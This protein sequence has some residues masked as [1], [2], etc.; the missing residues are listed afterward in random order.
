MK[1]DDRRWTLPQALAVI[2]D[3][4][5]EA[6]SDVE[7]R[8]GPWARGLELFD[9]VNETVR[10]AARARDEAAIALALRR[11]DEFYGRLCCGALIAYG[12]GPD[13]SEHKPIPASAWEMIDSFY[14]YDGRCDCGA[15]D[16][17]RSGESSPRYRDVFVWAKDVL[18][19]LTL[20][21]TR[22]TIE[23]GQSGRE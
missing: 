15:E 2:I 6:A 5:P 20:D 7:G 17:Y 18:L 9:V 1:A 19:L 3:G 11:R 10:A 14:N 8:A 21:G 12:I 4:T 23:P 16:V 22:A 13:Q